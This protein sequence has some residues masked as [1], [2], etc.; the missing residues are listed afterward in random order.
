M[1]IRSIQQTAKGE[2]RRHSTGIE[3]LARAGYFSKGVVYCLVG[4]IALRSAFQHSWRSANTHGA[5]RELLSKPFGKVLLGIVAVGLVGYAVWQFVRAVYD[6]EHPTQ[7]P[8]RTVMRLVYGLSAFVHLGLA[9]QAIRM[10]AGSHA[11]GGNSTTHWTAVLMSKP[12]GIFLVAGA[13]IGVL[14]F[15]GYQIYRGFNAKLDKR[16]NLGALTF[17]MRRAAIR[18]A[19]FGIMARGA[20]LGIVGWFLLMAARHHDPGRAEGLSEALHSVMGAPYGRWLLMIVSL[21]LIAYGIY[22]LILS[23]YRV[24]RPV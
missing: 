15:A 20:S 11:S 21:G 22:D 6:P 23:R 24:I 4:L 2:A 13:G 19:Q 7:S 18:V 12:F 14:A 5:F 3:K 16:L 10:S 17:P 1:S 9:W 8:K